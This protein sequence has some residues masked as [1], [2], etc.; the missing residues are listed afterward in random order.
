MIQ[1]FKYKQTILTEIG[2]G[3]ILRISLFQKRL[4]VIFKNKNSPYKYEGIQGYCFPIYF[5]Q[6][7]NI[8]EEHSENNIN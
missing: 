1:N 5:N 7:L 3:Q 2:I 8:L 4:I 6:V